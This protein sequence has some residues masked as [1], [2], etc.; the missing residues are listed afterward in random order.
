MNHAIA[1]E[2]QRSESMWRCMCHLAWHPGPQALFA[3]V[4]ADVDGWGPWPAHPRVLSVDEGRDTATAGGGM[5]LHSMRWEVCLLAT[6]VL[7]F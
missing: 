4:L 5:G 2:G 6:K 7:P 1:P 3:T